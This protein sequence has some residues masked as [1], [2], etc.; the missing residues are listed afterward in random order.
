MVFRKENKGIIL[1]PTIFRDKQQDL[2]GLRKMK[3]KEEEGG[4]KYKTPVLFLRKSEAGKH[5]F[6]VNREGEKGNMVLGEDVGSLILNLS[7]MEA[8]LAGKMK[9][10][11]VSVISAVD[12]EER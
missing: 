5:L 6:A 1:I 3:T 12:K 7:E 8:L 9:W 4:K 2:E 10:C 11:K